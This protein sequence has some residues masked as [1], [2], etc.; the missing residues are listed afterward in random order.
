MKTFSLYIFRIFCKNN[1]VYAKENWETREFHW[2]LWVVF[3][4]VSR[5]HM[6]PSSELCV[7]VIENLRL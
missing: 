7:W 3:E 4:K 1:S 6:L 5:V 2:L